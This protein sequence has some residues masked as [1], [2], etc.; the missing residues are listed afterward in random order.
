MNLRVSWEYALDATLKEN[1]ILR[2]CM[3]SSQNTT[4]L[5]QR[6]QL[7]L[8][9]K[10]IRPVGKIQNLRC[11]KTTATDSVLLIAL[12]VYGADTQQ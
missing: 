12:I 8:S 2:L 1:E 9:C 11:Q 5:R 6:L 10:E 4:K 3:Y 7:H